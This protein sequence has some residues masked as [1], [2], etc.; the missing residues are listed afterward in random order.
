M[1]NLKFWNTKAENKAVNINIE[2][3]SN[4][5]ATEFSEVGITDGLVAYYPLNGDAKDYSGNNNH[6]TV[7]GAI[8]ASGVAGKKCYYFDGT[9]DYILIN[10]GLLYGLSEFTLHFYYKRS[11]TSLNECLLCSRS[12]ATGEGVSVFLLNDGNI[13]LDTGLGYHWSTGKTIASNEEVFIDYIWT[14]NIK[15][16]YINGTLYGSTSSS[17]TTITNLSQTVTTIGASQV[18]GSSLGN[19]LGGNIQDVRIYNRAL[20]DK[21]IEILYNLFNPNINKTLQINK[22]NII[23]T[24]GNIK[25]V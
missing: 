15:K 23:Y 11:R 2:K 1:D 21:E 19:F 17:P 16:L 7:Y 20:S 12:G 13:R 22:E 3:T 6:G 4:I 18:N 9:N 10:D 14:P 24:K 5:V 8:K 25:E